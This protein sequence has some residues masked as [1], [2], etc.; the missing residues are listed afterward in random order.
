MAGTILHQHISTDALS[1]MHLALEG[2]CLPSKRLKH[3]AAHINLMHKPTW[4]NGGC[5]GGGRGGEGGVS[6]LVKNYSLFKMQG[7]CN[8]LMH[9]LLFK[10]Q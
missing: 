7:D 5:G 4:K 3:S 10:Q 2:E 9:F 8:S 1:D 6:G